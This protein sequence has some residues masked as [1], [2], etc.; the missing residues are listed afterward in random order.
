VET[1]VYAMVHGVEKFVARGQAPSGA[2]TG[3]NEAVELRDE[4]RKDRY[5]GK[6]VTKAVGHVTSELTAALK[7]M[8]PTNL[9]VCDQALCTADGT[10]LKSKLGGNAVTATSFAIAEAGALLL[11]KELFLHLG[12]SFHQTLPAKLSLPRPMVNILNGGKHAGGDLRIQEFMIV[13]KV[14][15]SFKENLRMCAEVYH[16]LGK[17]LVKKK[18]L[19]AKNLVNKN[20]II[21]YIFV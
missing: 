15:R 17:L 2:S 19:S 12:E 14:N 5:L 16:H 3:S 8:D 4:D 7:T 13:P 20:K 21:Y 6:G 9:R 11:Q 18:G 10:Q 1:D